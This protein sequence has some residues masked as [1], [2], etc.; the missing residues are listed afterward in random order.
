MGASK[1]KRTPTAIERDRI[2][3]L[4]DRLD[5]AITEHHRMRDELDALERRHP[6]EA[7]RTALRRQLRRLR[8]HTRV[9]G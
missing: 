4:K 5:A 1:R 9:G 6:L 7:L 8:R 2:K 3:A